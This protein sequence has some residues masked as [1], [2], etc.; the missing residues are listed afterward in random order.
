MRRG[1]ATCANGFMLFVVFLIFYPICAEAGDL[2][3]SSA[4]TK[5]YTTS[6]ATSSGAGDITISSTGYITVDDDAV[7][8]TIDSDNAVT[9]KGHIYAYD[10]G[11]TGILVS[12]DTSGGIVNSGTIIT[13]T[14]EDDDD[15]AVMGGP[16]IEVNADLGAGVENTGAITTYGAY[17]VLFAA[18]TQDLTVGATNTDDVTASVYNDGTIYAY[19]YA[20]STSGVTAIGVS[21]SGYTATLS[22]G[23]YNTEDGTILAYAY[24]Q[25]ATAIAI[26]DGGAVSGIFNEGLIEAYTTEDDGSGGDAVAID[27][28]S[29]GSLD[30]IENDETI[31]AYADADG[32]S[33]TA[34][35]DASGTL[36]SIVNTGTIKAEIGDTGEAIAIDLSDGNG[37]TAIEN[38]GDITGDFLF[39]GGS[40]TLK[41][42]DGTL[43]GAIDLDGGALAVTLSG[44]TE[45]LMSSTMTSGSTL[46]LDVE[47]ASF[48]VASDSVFYA[49]SAKFSSA[50][51]FLTSYDAVDG[52]SAGYLST[53]GAASFEDGATIDVD[54]TSYLSGSADILIADAGSLSGVDGVVIGGV[55]VGYDAS[56]VESGNSLYLELSR[57]TASALGYS[58]NLATIYNAAPTA[59]ESDDDLGSAVGNVETEAELQQAYEQLMPDITGARERHSVMAQDTAHDAIADRLNELRALGKGGTVRRSRNGWWA[60]EEA[61]AIDKSGDPNTG[62]DGFLYG[63]TIGYDAM[64]PSGEATGIAFVTTAEGYGGDYT[65]GDNSSIRSYAL[66]F[67]KGYNSGTLFWDMTG[68]LSYNSYTIRREIAIGD[69]DYA[70]TSDSSG[71]QGMMGADFGYR[72]DMGWLV[73][74]PS[75][76]AEY[77]YLY[78]DSYEE[79]GAGGANLAIDAGDFQSLRLKGSLKAAFGLGEGRAWQPFVEGGYT[80]E[81]LSEDAKADGRFV[82]GGSFSLTGD[83]VNESAPFVKAGLAYR[84]W[85][86]SLSLSYKGE[87]GDFSAHQAAFTASLQF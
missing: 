31:Y 63:L 1:C 14:A 28:A 82:S 67:Y 2:T 54:F 10:E 3:I 35:R 64:S 66:H 24:D 81:M 79:T 19:G 45:A 40:Y 42:T 26:L 11:G 68:G 18:D 74:T 7:A 85:G 4:K 77:T 60:R 30:T 5:S 57:K 70:A 12:S 62:Y 38:S 53:S 71:Y 83:Q 27:V 51:T 8:V 29:G 84:M 50:A 25:D 72:A 46:T 22:D 59:L 17:A 37:T 76:R 52:T 9:N 55:A 86:G 61:S 23:I 65:G 20:S 48:D 44:G 13:G 47:D 41:S 58:G 73:L 87:Y 6:A 36:S 34:I 80:G 49:T 69:V 32:T 75:L 33:A 43:T 15:D 56:L 78:M 39:G 21:G 16:A